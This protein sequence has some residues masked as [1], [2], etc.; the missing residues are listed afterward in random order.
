MS[1]PW[2]TTG[3][4]ERTIHASPEIIYHA[5]ADIM[6]TG[7]RSDEC[8]RAE[9]LGDLEE[10]V[11]G[12]RFRGYNRFGLARWSRVCEIIDARPGVAFAYR[13]VPERWDPSRRD[14]TEW[15][16]ELTRQSD[17]TLVEHSYTIVKPPL[18]PFKRLYGRIFPQHRDMRPAMEY[19]L[20][21]LARSL[22][23]P[24]SEGTAPRN[25]PVQADIAVL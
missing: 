20:D 1:R 7:D 2:R 17:G 22:E 21:A 14:S 6:S 10:A 3:T 15:R 23:R 19:T 24:A 16:Y 8:R 18:P 4:V 13:T 9:W 25:R 5:I 12:A 11:I